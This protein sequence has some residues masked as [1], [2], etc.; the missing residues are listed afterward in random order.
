[1]AEA[2]ENKYDKITHVVE[3]KK[4]LYYKNMSVLEMY[5]NVDHHYLAKHFKVFIDTMNQLINCYD[6]YYHEIQPHYEHKEEQTNQQISNRKAVFTKQVSPILDTLD[7]LFGTSP[8]SIYFAPLLEIA[9]YDNDNNEKLHFVPKIRLNTKPLKGAPWSDGKMSGPAVDQF[10]IL[11]GF[12]VGIL[13]RSHLLSFAFMDFQS[14]VDFFRNIQYDRRNS[15]YHGGGHKLYYWRQMTAF[16]AELNAKLQ[17]DNGFAAQ[18]K[19]EYVHQ[20]Q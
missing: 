17:D 4:K 20:E 14:S 7:E 10:K 19:H 12:D 9:G 3:S 2:D 1:M 8:I 6:A 5:L 16:L 15:C 13:K 18:S 11:F